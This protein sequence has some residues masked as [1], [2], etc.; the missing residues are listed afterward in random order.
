[1][2]IKTIYEQLN[3]EVCDNVNLLINT[4]RLHFEQAQLFV[5]GYLNY[6]GFGRAIKLLHLDANMNPVGVINDKYFESKVSCLAQSD[7][8]FWYLG[9][10]LEFAKKYNEELIEPK[11]STIIGIKEQDGTFQLKLLNSKQ[12]YNASIPEQLVEF[13]E[14]IVEEVRSDF[15]LDLI[16]KNKVS[17]K[18]GF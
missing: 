15:S 8:G 3:D 1:M 5:A 10:L 2:T 13:Y 9:F 6:I 14:K 17:K 4:E 12:I 16:L 11:D 18:I 7:D